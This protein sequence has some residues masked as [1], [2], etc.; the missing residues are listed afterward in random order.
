LTCRQ[1]GVS[2]I[3]LVQRKARLAARK[4]LSMQ[5]KCL[6]ARAFCEIDTGY[7]TPRLAA[8]GVADAGA[9]LALR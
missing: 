9:G 1:F 8:D 7:E 6:L 3:L 4:Y 5:Q 2:D